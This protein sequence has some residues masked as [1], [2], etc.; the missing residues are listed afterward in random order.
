MAQPQPGSQK[1]NFPLMTGPPWSR[2]NNNFKLAPGTEPG[3]QGN[4][5]NGVIMGPLNNQ[6]ANFQSST[7]LL[8]QSRDQM[9]DRL[10]ESLAADSNI[11]IIPGFSPQ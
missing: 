6:R 5:T 3:V 10:A 4:F 9:K 7:P 1:L 11:A 2:Y 8:V